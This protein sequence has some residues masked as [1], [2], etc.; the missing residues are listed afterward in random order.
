MFESSTAR[1]A[2]GILFT[3]LIGI[4][5]NAVAADSAEEARAEIAKNQFRDS[6]IPA[7]DRTQIDAAVTARSLETAARRI[8]PID[9]AVKKD[10]EP[11]WNHLGVDFEEATLSGDKYVQELPNGSTVTFSIDPQLQQH[12]EATLE[13]YEV[14]HGSVILLDPQTG[15]VQAMVSQTRRKPYMEKLATKA[16]APA[17]SVFKIVTAT[18]LLKET[19]INPSRSVCYSGGVSRLSERQITSPLNAGRSCASLDEALAN[20]INSI[21]GK[22]AYRHL[23]QKQLGKWARRFHF[24]KPIPFD[25]P[26]ERS[27]ATIVDDPIERSRTAAGFWHTFMSPLHGAL[28]SAAIINDG[29]MMAPH[30]VEEMKDNNGETLYDAEPRRMHRVVDAQTAQ[31]LQS[32]LKGTATEGTADRYFAHRPGFPHSIDVGGKTGTLANENPYLSFSWFVGFGDSE[33][34]ERKAA[35]SS[36]VCNKPTWRIKGPYVASEG[37]NLY[38]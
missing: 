37:L 1:F 23:S 21:F 31:T 28:I 2:A 10:S 8:K 17:A 12:L 9:L 36:L 14:P 38:F 20:S 32:L 4:C 30:L 16:T 5:I 3:G 11:N 19:D 34:G 6:D 33:N 27:Q 7:E 24:N 15:A 35:I 26:V 18:A 13:K 25:F 22:L 29:V